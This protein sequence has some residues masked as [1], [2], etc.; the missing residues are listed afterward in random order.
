M[1]VEPKGVEHRPVA[2][3]EVHL[4]LIEPTGT[5]N[6]GDYN[7]VKPIGRLPVRNALIGPGAGTSENSR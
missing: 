3:D 2:R 7:W 5:P 1:Y 6:T 4:V